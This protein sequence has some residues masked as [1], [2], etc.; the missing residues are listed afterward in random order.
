[1][2]YLTAALLAIP[3]G[4]IIW[5]EVL[6][7]GFGFTQEDASPALNV[8]A[9]ALAV[10]VTLGWPLHRTA[11]AAAAGR[12]ACR[13]G[14]AASLLLP[15]VAVAVLLLWE[16]ASDR[17]DLGMGG[18]MLYNMPIIAGVIA[19]VLVIPFWIGERLFARR[20]AWSL[21]SDG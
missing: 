8:T 1:M 14:I 18:L 16:S 4:L 6:Y 2:R 20:E 10:V 19:F 15:V 7:L 21:A 3:V 12:R 11:S 5:V 9:I 17:P 13:L